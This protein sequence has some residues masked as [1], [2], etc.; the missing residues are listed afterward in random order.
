MIPAIKKDSFTL[1]NAEDFIEFLKSK[2][3]KVQK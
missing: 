2:G 3:I 1:G